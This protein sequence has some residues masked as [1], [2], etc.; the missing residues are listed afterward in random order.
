MTEPQKPNVVDLVDA[1]V[2]ADQGLAALGMLMQLAG[3]VL[4]AY[5]ALF[6]F[7]VLFAGPMMESGNSQTLWMFLI[8][9]LSITRSLFHRAAGSA[10]VYGDP[11]AGG[12]RLKGVQRYIGFSLAQ[13]VVLGA[14]LWGEFHTSG[15]IAVSV[16]LG[17]AVWP[18]MLVGLFALP[19]FRRFKDELPLTEDKG[20]EGASILMTV[21]GLC[22]LIGTA[23]A[24]ILLVQQDS[25]ELQRGPNVLIALSL[26]ML[27]IR[28]VLHVQAGISGLRETSVDRS[29]EL[30]NRYANFGVISSFCG[31]GALL[32][33]VM[34]SAM[35]VGGL[36]I[37]CGLCWMLLAW[38]MIIRK[39]YS[40]RQFADLLAGD[41]APIH[42]RAP[43]AGITWLGWLLIAQGAFAASFL[44]PELVMEPGRGAAAF[45]SMFALA[46]AFGVRSM[47][48]NV[49]LLALQL[50]AGYELVRMSPQSKV[51]ATLY[52]IAGIAIT[53]Y[54]EWPLLSELRHHGGGGISKDAV[55]FGPLALAL[56]I[57][58]ATIVLV[59]RKIAPTARARFR[60]KPPE[61]SETPA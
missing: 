50:W 44:I 57:P 33:F 40:D 15:K 14:L 54:L 58:V 9:G 43:D 36:A 32:L 11:G 21:L 45:Q 34:S 22:G 30:A 13:S 48:W 47:W 4:A 17:L 25:H 8:L 49:G 42:R 23:T 16:T 1:G 52:G 3:N 59:H 61:G 38:P 51:I 18:A 6:A 37:V 19:R 28:S 29:V 5:A 2:P 10:L 31:G 55:M 35:N 12:A 60:T 24:L 7:A 20:F 46:G 26:V 53:L 39:F 41:A 27:C 56:V